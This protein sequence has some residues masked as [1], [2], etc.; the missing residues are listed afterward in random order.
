MRR[1]VLGTSLQ[2]R[3]MSFSRACFL[4]KALVRTRLFFPRYSLGIDQDIQVKIN[5]GTVTR[6]GVI[7]TMIANLFVAQYMTAM[8]FR[9]ADL[10]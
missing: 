10:N 4:K 6:L 2:M 7:R 8:F 1:S 9:D 5:H 3:R